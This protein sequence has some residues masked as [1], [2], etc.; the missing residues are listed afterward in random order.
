M[1]ENGMRPVWLFEH[2][3]LFRIQANSESRNRL[4]PAVRAHADYLTTSF[5]LIDEPHRQAGNT[6]VDWIAANRER[7]ALGSDTPTRGCRMP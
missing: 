2:R 3:R 7:Y 4:V 1:P 6:L 5:D